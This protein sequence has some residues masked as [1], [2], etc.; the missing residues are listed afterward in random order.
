MNHHTTHE[1]ETIWRLNSKFRWLKNYFA[2]WIAWKW[3]KKNI[4]HTLKGQII[5]AF[6]QKQGWLIKIVFTSQTL[7]TDLTLFIY[8]ILNIVNR[9]KM[10]YL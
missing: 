8:Y 4:G 9:K 10:S 5:S 6:A 2:K 1:F 7:A 3:N